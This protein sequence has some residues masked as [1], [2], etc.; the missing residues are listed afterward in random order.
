MYE[1]RWST[2]YWLRKIKWCQRH[3]TIKPNLLYLL[4][5][6][7]ISQYYYKS[8]FYSESSW[9]NSH[10]DC[11]IPHFQALILSSVSIRL[12]KCRMRWKHFSRFSIWERVPLRCTTS[13]NES[14][15]TSRFWIC[16]V[17]ELNTS[18]RSTLSDS[19]SSSHWSGSTTRG[20]WV[21][22]EDSLSGL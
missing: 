7:L 3:D 10:L 8:P 14:R 6:V 1:Q 2:L 5:H 11:S 21:T 22:C 16:L 13:R 9:L 19:T 12:Y 4:L 17:M 15:W 20:S 18:C